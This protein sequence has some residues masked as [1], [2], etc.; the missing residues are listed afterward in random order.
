M[1]QIPSSQLFTLRVWPELTEDGQIRWRG[2]LR[3]IPSDTVHYFR[4]WAALVPLL[5]SILR[6]YPPADSSQA[7]TPFNQ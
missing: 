1:A 3:H 4:D 7:I 2:K 5:L 6:R